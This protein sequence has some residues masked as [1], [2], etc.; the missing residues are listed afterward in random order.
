MS[1]R[2]KSDVANQQSVAIAAVESPRFLTCW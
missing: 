1:K 2:A